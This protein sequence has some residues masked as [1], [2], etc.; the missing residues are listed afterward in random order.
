METKQ[1]IIIRADLRNKSGNKVH[2]GKII[3]QAC[4]ASMS[5]LTKQLDDGINFA[6]YS[7]HQIML[8]E[9][10]MSWIDSSFRKIVLKANSHAHLMEL[11]NTALSLGLTTHLI[12]DAGYTEFSEPTDTCIAIGPHL[13]SKITFTNNLGLY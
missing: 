6:G 5:F 10:E 11:Y 7:Q 2:S 12:T 13:S 9:E 1:V 3:A 4:H 8:S